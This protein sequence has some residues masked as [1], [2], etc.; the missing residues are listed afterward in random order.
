MSQSQLQ[1]SHMNTN[2]QDNVVMDQLQVLGTIPRSARGSTRRDA[3][4]PNN[5]GKNLRTDQTVCL[6]T[7]YCS[8]EK[9]RT[10]RKTRRGRSAVQKLPPTKKHHFCLNGPPNG[11]QPLVD[12]PPVADFPPSTRRLS[13]NEQSRNLRTARTPPQSHALISQTAEALE[14]RFRGDDMR[15]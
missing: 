3:K 1:K 12:C 4:E 7:T 11:P 8:L 2:R 10:V 9:G 15:H 5:L 14:P 6:A 13:E